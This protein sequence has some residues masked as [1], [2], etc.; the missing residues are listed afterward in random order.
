MRIPVTPPAETPVSLEDLKRHA[1]LK[2]SATAEDSELTGYLRAAVRMCEGA[3][4]R[5]FVDQTWRVHLPCFSSLVRLG[6]GAARVASIS[7]LDADGVQQ[8]LADFQERIVF[9][10]L[11][12]FPAPGATWPA[13]QADT[14]RAVTID[15]VAGFGGA[16]D[17]PDD[18][19]DAILITALELYERRTKTEVG[20]VLARHDTVDSLLAPYK[21]WSVG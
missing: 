11:E 5:A 6:Y 14:V 3:C 9:A 1:R 7:Y 4:G 13:V 17:V 8:T 10:G 15:Y 21:V 19:K 2:V 12:V 18:I 20:T 16:A